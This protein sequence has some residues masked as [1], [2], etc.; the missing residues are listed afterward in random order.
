MTFINGNYKT[1]I[2]K[3]GNGYQIYE[4]NIATGKGGKL[5]KVETLQEAI[6]YAN[7]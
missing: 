7:N 3:E 4:Y 5:V 2:A 6:D 1:I